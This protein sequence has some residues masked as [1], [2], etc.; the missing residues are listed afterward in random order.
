M[1][2]KYLIALL[3]PLACCCTG[4]TPDDSGK[5][6]PEQERIQITVMSYNMLFEH[7]VP[8]EPERQWASRCPN[9][10]A[11]INT[12]KPDVIGAQEIQ[13][14]QLTELLKEIGYGRIGCSLAG[15]TSE[16]DNNEN[17]AILYNK[18]RLKCITSG[19]FWF[20][21]HPDTAGAASGV[22]YNRMCNWAKFQIIGSDKTFYVYNSHFYV[23]TEA[24]RLDCAKILTGRIAAPPLAPVFLT[25]DFN[26]E[27]TDSSLKHILASGYKD[28]RSLASDPKGP[29]GSWY[30]FDLSSSP[31]YRLDH[32]L[33][34]SYVQV[35]EYEIIDAQIKTGAIESDHLPVL[36]KAS[37]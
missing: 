19:H 7:T 5:D 12:L 1:D 15:T 27:I 36:V 17:E 23:E 2:F 29:A 28:S 16:T 6:V 34:N 10:A 20:N 3:I 33:V 35:N 22:S 24:L 14:Y 30:N 11:T 25:G 32:I 21:G 9:M 4:S 8:A 37:L 13:S 18:E 31:T 26:A